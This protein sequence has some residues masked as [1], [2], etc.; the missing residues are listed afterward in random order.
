MI[1]LSPLSLQGRISAIS[2]V[3]SVGTVKMESEVDRRRLDCVSGVAYGLERQ[4]DDLQ[5]LILEQNPC[6]KSL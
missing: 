4:Q 3:S 5:V 2:T 6:R 1:P